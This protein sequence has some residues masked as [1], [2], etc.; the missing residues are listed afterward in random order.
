ML[1]R[2]LPLILA[3]PQPC[4]I[5]TEA[6]QTDT[7]IVITYTEVHFHVNGTGQWMKT[8]RRVRV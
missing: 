3:K 5:Y 6:L 4:H 2:R 8:R 7:V 1:P